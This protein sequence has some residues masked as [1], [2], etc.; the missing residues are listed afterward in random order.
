MKIHFLISNF[1][2]S[3]TDKLS[4]HPS[5]PYSAVYFLRVP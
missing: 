5:I 3:V 2:S 4:R 1:L